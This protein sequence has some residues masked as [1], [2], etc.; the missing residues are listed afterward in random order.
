MA[1]SEMLQTL[2]ALCEDY[3]ASDLHLAVGLAPRFR[4]RGALVP[5]GDIR[6]F[7]MKDVDA[8][9]IELGLTTLPIGSSDGSARIRLTLLKEGSIDGAVTSPSGER[10]RFNVCRENNRHAVTLRRLDSKFRTFAE[11]GI[12]R[13]VA[14]FCRERDG[15]FLVS[16]PT[17]SG[18]STTLATMIDS[19]NHTLCGHIITIEDPVEFLHES[20]KCIVKQRQ[21]GRDTKS[22]ND[23]LV[24]ALRQDPDVILVGEL[25]DLD[26]MRTALRAAETGHLVLATVHA[27]D[28][29]GAIERLLSV[30]PPDEQE[31]ARR[32]LALVLRGICAQHLIIGTDG[33]RHP[34]CELMVNTSACANVIATGRS[35]LQ[36]YSL[37]ETGGNVGMV[38]LDQSL[39][40]L[41]RSGLVDAHTA[42][43][44]SR[45]PAQLKQILGI[46]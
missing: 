6:P 28:C 30:F 25:R 42:I 12:P 16:G 2:F 35:S 41:V 38:S 33:L 5:K 15:L 14:D 37:M 7:D 11:L 1:M 10:Y 20:D 36:L 32:Q 23:A 21:V 27:G 26:T 8:I 44:L 24:E 39:T 46:Q 29:T 4:I 19:I 17:G 31:S 45:Y 34:A 40:A 22:F 43:A 18:K 13:R 9:A 3:E